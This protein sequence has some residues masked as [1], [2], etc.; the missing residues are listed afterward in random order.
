MTARVEIDEWTIDFINPDLSKYFHVRVTLDD[1]TKL[2][3]TVPDV[4]P[5]HLWAVL[6]SVFLG[7]VVVGEVEPACLTKEVL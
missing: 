3:D 1:L 7:G 4:F 2:I 6:V 5:Y